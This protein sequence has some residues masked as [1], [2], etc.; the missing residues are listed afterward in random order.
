MIHT[1]IFKSGKKVKSLFSTDS[2]GREIFRAT[3]SNNGFNVLIRALRLND[4]ATRKNRK[5]EDPTAA[6][7]WLF[8]TSI[9]NSQTNFNMGSNVCIKEMLMSFRSKCPFKTYMP[10]K[11]VRNGIKI[12]ALTDARNNYFYNG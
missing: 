9:K 12:I 11:P 4:P 7:S 1:S 10:S 3:M 5:D 6:I 2:T 8:Q